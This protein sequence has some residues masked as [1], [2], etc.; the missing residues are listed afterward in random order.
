M[1][2]CGGG[3]SN[4]NA[5]LSQPNVQK[6]RRDLVKGRV[7]GLKFEKI[8]AGKRIKSTPKKKLGKGSYL[9]YFVLFHSPQP[10]N[11]GPARP[12]GGTLIFSSYIGSG[13]ASTIH[14]KIISEISSTPK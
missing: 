2:V 10:N 5:S 12:M 14:P 9:V 3:H 1:C 8:N 4:C 13:P 6:N 11:I 7:G